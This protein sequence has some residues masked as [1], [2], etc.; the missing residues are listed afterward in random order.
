[1]L[2]R[3]MPQPAAPWDALWW[4]ARVH[5]AIFVHRVDGSRRASTCWSRDPSAVDR[6]QAACG[7]EFLWEPV[8]DA[9]PLF[10]LARGD[11]R[12]ARP[13]SELRSGH[14]GRRLLQPRDDRGVRRE[15]AR[16]SARR[17]T[18]ICSGSRAWSG[19]CCISR[20]KPP[21]RAPPASAASTT[22]RCTTSSGSPITLSEPV[23]LHG[24]HA[25]RGHAAHDGTRLLVGAG[26]RSWELE[27]R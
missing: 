5:L 3:V 15:P 7:R 12:G 2:S 27:R 22:I 23:S 25:G 19:R 13:S 14:R 17:S 11:C 18:V 8:G 26:A 16:R 4:D 1:M 10:L 6:L 21:A 20:P 24:R 9:L